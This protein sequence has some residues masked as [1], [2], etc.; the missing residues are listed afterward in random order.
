V[1]W[2]FFDA[3]HAK[4]I[5]A[6]KLNKKYGMT[7]SMTNLMEDDIVVGLELSMLIFNIRK[8]LCDVLNGFISFLTKYI[9]KTPNMISLM[10]DPNF[11]NIILVSFFI[12][13][14]QVISMMEDYDRKYLFPMSLKC[15]HIFQPMVEFF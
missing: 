15:H 6:L 8:Q 7:P 12:G 4:I 11:K 2:L 3:L 1:H 13:K 5:M 14:K 10:L 9:K